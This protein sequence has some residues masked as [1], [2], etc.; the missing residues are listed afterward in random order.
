[1]KDSDQ[2]RLSELLEE[3]RKEL[4]DERPD[5]R[6]ELADLLAGADRDIHHLMNRNTKDHHEVGEIADRMHQVALEFYSEHPLLSRLANDV[7]V[8]LKRLGI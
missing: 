7:V 3:L 5:L 2:H 1:M 4:G 6:K 8:M